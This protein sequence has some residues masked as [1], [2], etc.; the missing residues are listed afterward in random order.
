MKEILEA[1][2]QMTNVMEQEKAS[3]SEECIQNAANEKLEKINLLLAPYKT[4]LD[5]LPPLVPNCYNVFQINIGTTC[6]GETVWLKMTNE[7]KI[8]NYW[9][10]IGGK[11]Y[12]P[13]VD[14]EYKHLKVKEVCINTP[15]VQNINID[16]VIKR[17]KENLLVLITD[18]IKKCQV[19]IAERQKALKAFNVNVCVDS[20]MDDLLD[21]LI[22]TNEQFKESNNVELINIISLIIDNIKT[23]RKEV[24]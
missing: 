12:S 3:V 7:S 8:Y 9:I 2:S 22:D 1:L 18:I 23:I 24:N 17:V 16:Y 13:V 15:V 4:I 20:T 21:L 19:R 11:T 10:I 14:N 5:N 6:V